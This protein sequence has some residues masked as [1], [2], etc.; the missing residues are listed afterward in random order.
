MIEILAWLQIGFSLVAIAFLLLTGMPVGAASPL[1]LHRMA[2]PLGEWIGQVLGM[3]AFFPA[4][5][6]YAV[7]RHRPR[8][9]RWIHQ[10]PR[11]EQ[12]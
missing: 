6:L 7:R 2:E 3:Y 4:L 8:L 11:P 5:V 9:L 12:A 10:D 1:E